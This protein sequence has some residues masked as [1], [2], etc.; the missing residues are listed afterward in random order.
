MR[1]LEKGKNTKIGYKRYHN[2]TYG[3]R[4]FKIDKVTTMR[5]KGKKKNST[6]RS[7]GHV[8]R[9]SGKRALW[10]KAIVKLEKDHKIDLV[11]G[12]F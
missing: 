6:I 10:K 8:L 5:F 2:K 4:V 7:G 11:E 3:E 12:D 9:T 1:L